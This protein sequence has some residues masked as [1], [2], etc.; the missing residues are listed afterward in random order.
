MMTYPVLVEGKVRQRIRIPE[1][2]AEVRWKFPTWA[3]NTP[4][5]SENIKCMR[6]EAPNFDF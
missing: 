4:S 3:V 2:L 6:S 1:Y 5:P